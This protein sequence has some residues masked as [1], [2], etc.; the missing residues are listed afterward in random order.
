LKFNQVKALE[1]AEPG[2]VHSIYNWIVDNVPYSLEER[3]GEFLRDIDDFVLANGSSGRSIS[4]A[5][6]IEKLLVSC[7]SRRPQNCLSRWLSVC[8]SVYTEQL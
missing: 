5:N 3:E 4:R 1:K 7:A 2:N 8:F 6:P